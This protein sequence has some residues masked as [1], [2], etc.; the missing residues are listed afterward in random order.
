MDPIFIEEENLDEIA[1]YDEETIEQIE[2]ER[3]LNIIDEFKK[4][5]KNEP[6]FISIDNISSI[7]IYNLTCMDHKFTNNILTEHQIHLFDKMFLSIFDY[8]TTRSN[9]NFIA[10]KIFNRIYII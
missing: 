9:Y 6:E 1:E 5:I 7:E 3:C 10:N 8:S 2:E 4:E